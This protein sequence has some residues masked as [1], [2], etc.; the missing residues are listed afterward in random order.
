LL[1]G[2]TERVITIGDGVMATLLGTPG[3]VGKTQIFSLNLPAHDIEL[4]LSDRSATSGRF[5][6][7]HAG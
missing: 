1:T 5:S 4:D 3:E 6:Y 2:A 7:A